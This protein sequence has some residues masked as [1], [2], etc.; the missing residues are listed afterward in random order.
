MFCFIR[1]FLDE[2]IYRLVRF[3][4]RTLL[5]NAVIISTLFNIMIKDLVSLYTRS[6]LAY[7]ADDSSM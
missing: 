2:R 4:F 3:L 1:Y 7:F 5:Y 6:D